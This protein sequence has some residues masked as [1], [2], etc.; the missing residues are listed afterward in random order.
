MMALSSEEYERL[1]RRMNLFDTPDAG[2]TWD[3]T[4]AHLQAMRLAGG[5]EHDERVVL[6]GGKVARA[7]TAT[8]LELYRWYSVVSAA[9]GRVW[10]YAR[11]PHPSGRNRLLNDGDERGRMARFLREAVRDRA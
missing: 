9:D 11:V 5:F 1:T 2:K 3:A 8:A 4:E 7:F 10:W 6:L